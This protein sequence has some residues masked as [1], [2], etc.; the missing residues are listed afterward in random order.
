VSTRTLG[1]LIVRR[2]PRTGQARSDSGHEGRGD[3]R[4]SPPVAGAAP[5]GRPA[6]LHTHR[7][8]RARDHG[9][10]H[11]AEA[12]VGAPGH[13][14]DPPPL[15]SGVAALPL[16][17]PADCSTRSALSTYGSS[18]SSSGWPTRTQGGATCGSSASAASWASPC[19]RPRC[20]PSCAPRF[21]PAPRR[22]GPSWTEFLR[23]QAAGTIACDFLTVETAGPTRLSCCSSSS[24]TAAAFA[25]RA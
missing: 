10:T 21:G 8:P 19:P 14:V 12:L 3:R 15:A 25:W 11:P 7:S 5:A 6:P 2:N 1:F 18:S 13:P 17:L 22:G 23:A 24:W 16:D 9:E 4:A 20:A